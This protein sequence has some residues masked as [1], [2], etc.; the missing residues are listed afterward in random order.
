MHYNVHSV[1]YS[2]CF[3]PQFSAAVIAIFRAILLLLGYRVTAN[4]ICTFVF[5]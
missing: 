1:F 5:W 4:H 2:H 3:H